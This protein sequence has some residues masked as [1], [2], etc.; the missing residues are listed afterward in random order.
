MCCCLL[1]L[2]AVNGYPLHSFLWSVRSGHAAQRRRVVSVM[3]CVAVATDSGTQE[4]IFY[5]VGQMLHGAGAAWRRGRRLNL[6][7][8]IDVFSA[9]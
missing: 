9:T 8:D 4:I 6:N 5:V 3:D 2:D 1:E 7:K